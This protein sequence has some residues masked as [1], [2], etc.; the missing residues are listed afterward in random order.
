MIYAADAKHNKQGLRRL[1]GCAEEDIKYYKD[2]SIFRCKN[3]LLGAHR[4][5]DSSSMYKSRYTGVSCSIYLLLIV[6]VV[7][8]VQRGAKSA[9]VLRVNI[10]ARGP[11]KRHQLRLAADQKARENQ[12]L[13]TWRWR[14]YIRRLFEQLTCLGSISAQRRSRENSQHI[15][16]AVARVDSSLIAFSGLA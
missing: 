4:Y 10:F 14:C 7:Q 11:S 5:R 2:P 16:A 1:R 13:H 8:S 6:V 9:E 15:G 12:H 3:S